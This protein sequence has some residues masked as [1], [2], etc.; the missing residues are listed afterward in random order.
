M[1]ENESN[2]E[3][4]VADVKN[5]DYDRL[6]ELIRLCVF[7][8]KN[9]LPVAQ[10]L[11]FEF[12][13]LRQEG[14]V[15]LLYALHSY[16]SAFGAGFKTYSSL[17]IRRRFASV[18]RMTNSSKHLSMADYV[19]IDDEYALPEEPDWMQKVEL[20]DIKERLLRLLSKLEK[21]VFG[22]YLGGFSY[23]EISAKLGKSE[24]A[25]GN[26]LQRV[27]EKLKLVV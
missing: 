2:I 13:D 23:R 24:K 15:A 22:L 25:V 21:D 3:K 12:D 7:V 5:G 17:C 6:D 16:D 11:G 20:S 8:P 19:S 4:I 26:A 9:A 14:V 1:S 27:K 10:K 18:L